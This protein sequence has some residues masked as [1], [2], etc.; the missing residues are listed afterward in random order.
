MSHPPTYNSLEEHIN[1]LHG[2]YLAKL[3]TQL[4]E[5][6]ASEIIIEFVKLQLSR[7]TNDIKYQALSNKEYGIKK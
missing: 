5:V 4:T 3:V 7:Y 2:R 1:K 6:R